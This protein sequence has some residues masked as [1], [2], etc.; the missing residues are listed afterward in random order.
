M[1]LILYDFT[2]SNGI[3]REVE[4]AAAAEKGLQVEEV[5]EST[6]K[7]VYS[8][9]ESDYNTIMPISSYV[10]EINVYRRVLNTV[11][12]AILYSIAINFENV[13]DLP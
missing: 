13:V 6:L 3:T 11:Y 10:L 5:A 7:I 9:S 8:D 12:K 2:V 4:E 1:H